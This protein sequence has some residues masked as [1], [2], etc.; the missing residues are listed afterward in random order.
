LYE[1]KI[2]NALQGDFGF[3]SFRGIV[4]FPF[5]HGRSEIVDAW[6]VKAASNGHDLVFE[7]GFPFFWLGDT[8]WELFHRLTIPE[9]KLYLDNRASKGFNV[10]QAVALAE[11]DGIRKPNRYGQTPFI[12][13]D[14]SSLNESYF[15]L[16]D[17]VR[18]EPFIL[19][20]IL[21]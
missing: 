18:Q 12:N 13:N 7:D 17:S 1:N 6:S 14:A 4:S 19:T 20:R 3:I 9:I 5:C 8:G 16:M 21:H 11:F 10:I 15:K 2:R